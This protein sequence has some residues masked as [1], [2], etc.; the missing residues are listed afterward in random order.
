[1]IRSGEM[2]GI[3]QANVSSELF[4]EILGTYPKP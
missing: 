1:M 2:L 4:R 3:L